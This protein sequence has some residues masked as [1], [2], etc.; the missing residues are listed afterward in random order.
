MCKI[1]P[2]FLIGIL[3][4]V[5][6]LFAQTHIQL[7]TEEKEFLHKNAPLR[8]HNELNWPPFNFYENG[9]AKG[10]SIDYLNL[11][12]Q[13]LDVEISYITGPSWDEF[14]HMLQEDKI[15]AIINISKN[16]ERAKTI[17]FTSIFHT[18]ANA[19]YVKKGNES[20]DSLEK[21][22]GKTVVMPKGF[23]AQKALEKYYPKINQILVKDSLE[24]LKMLSLGKAEATIGKKNVL[25][26]CSML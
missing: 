2:Q 5:H 10:F 11:L 4:F 3:F 18:A 17:A 22:E 16:E 14:I 24:A 20:L 6:T 12:A 21:L 25:D 19:I 1:L 26:I 9:E 8:L 23:F 13:K 7:T 15:D